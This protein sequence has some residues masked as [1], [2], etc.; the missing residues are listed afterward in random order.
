MRVNRSLIYKKPLQYIPDDLENWNEAIAL[1]DEAGAKKCL[2][3]L[4]NVCL[5]K[6]T[7][8]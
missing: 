2:R 1:E 7:K 3:K 8:L 5:S 4:F 6:Q